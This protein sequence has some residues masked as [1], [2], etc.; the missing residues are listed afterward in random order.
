MLLIFVSYFCTRL[1]LDPGARSSCGIHSMAFAILLG[2]RI[3]I[4]KLIV[5]TL[6]LTQSE[7]FAAP[8]YNFSPTVIGFSI[9]P[10]WSGRS[11]TSY[12][13]P[14]QWLDQYAAHA[15]K[16]RHQRAR[17]EI[18]YNDTLCHNYDHWQF[19]SGVWVWKEVR[20]EGKLFSIS[21]LPITSPFDL[22]TGGR[23]SQNEH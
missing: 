1:W 17:D 9:S 11:W 20:L 7:N 12:G 8:P 22:W 4:S 18:T 13:R 19:C 23:T 21:T 10:S 5:L 2:Q 6:N 3:L 16:S 14:A 15:S